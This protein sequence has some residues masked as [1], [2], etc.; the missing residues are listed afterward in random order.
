VLVRSGIF[1]WLFLLWWLFIPKHST[2]SSK[3]HITDFFYVNWIFFVDIVGKI[4]ITTIEDWERGSGYG[5]SWL[6]IE[7]LCHRK[8]SMDLLSP[9]ILR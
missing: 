1:P 6:S 7:F 4:C 9:I 8:I 2:I 3:K 5:V